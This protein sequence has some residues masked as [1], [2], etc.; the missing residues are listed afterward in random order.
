VNEARV[1]RIGELGFRGYLPGKQRGKMRSVP[2]RAYAASLSQGVL[3]TGGKRQWN[4][5]EMMRGVRL[6]WQRFWPRR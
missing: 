3:S 2:H 5:R 6:K 4:W 1:A